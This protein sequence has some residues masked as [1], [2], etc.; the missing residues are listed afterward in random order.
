MAGCSFRT[1]RRES[2]HKS[3]SAS[4]HGSRCRGYGSE[5]TGV[6]QCFNTVRSGHARVTCALEKDRHS[7]ERRFNP[8]LLLSL[9]KFD[10]ISLWPIRVKLIFDKAHIAAPF[11]AREENV[12][13]IRPCVHSD[14]MF[15]QI[16]H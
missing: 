1:S 15:L 3:I 10:L 13:K 11:H 9:H 4:H 16:L 5:P 8:A 12:G 14:A 2:D 7:L 6:P